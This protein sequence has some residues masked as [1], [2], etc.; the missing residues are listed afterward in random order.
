MKIHTI[1]YVMTYDIIYIYDIISDVY[2]IIFM[3]SCVWCHE[4]M[5]QYV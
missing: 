5:D 4:I 3:I 1:S 2:Y